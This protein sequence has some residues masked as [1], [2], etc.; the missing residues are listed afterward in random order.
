MLGPLDCSAGATIAWSTAG[1]TTA[2]LSIL[3]VYPQLW[4]HLHPRFLVAS[5][6]EFS[7]RQDLQNHLSLEGTRVLS[8][9]Y[10]STIW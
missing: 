10:F 3:D 8:A 6:V 1:A 5:S 2:R 7:G 9:V 4:I